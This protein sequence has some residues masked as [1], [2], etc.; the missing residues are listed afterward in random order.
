MAGRAHRPPSGPAPPGA[1]GG[2]RRGTVHP[3][4]ARLRAAQRH[5]GA[6]PGG[7]FRAA[8]RLRGRGGADPARSG[9]R[10]PGRVPDPLLAGHGGHTPLP[11]PLPGDHRR[12]RRPGHRHR[13]AHRARPAARG[14]PVHRPRPPCV[15]G[16]PGRP[17][18]SGIPPRRA[19]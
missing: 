8:G 5:R 18:V 7:R 10:G 13:L 3:A 1:A 17:L 15:G 4:Q 2:G 6:V 11:D 19:A 16:R 14:P 9:R 12:A